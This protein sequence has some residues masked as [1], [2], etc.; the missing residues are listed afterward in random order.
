MYDQ[1]LDALFYDIF[2]DIDECSPGSISDQYKD[3][4]HNCHVDAICSNTKGSFYCTCHK[5]YSGDGVI[6]QGN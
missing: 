4:A 3:L 5:G 2:S 1:N 6:C